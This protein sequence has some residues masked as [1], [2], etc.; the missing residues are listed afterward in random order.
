MADLV[1]PEPRVP[2]GVPHRQPGTIVP[3]RPAPQ[4]CRMFN[5]P[6]GYQYRWRPSNNATNDV[7]VSN[8][9]EGLADMQCPGLRLRGIVRGRSD[10]GRQG[11]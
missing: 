10:G 2:V 6:D 7:V 8:D 5:G 4:N 11:L 3:D 1:R 9:G